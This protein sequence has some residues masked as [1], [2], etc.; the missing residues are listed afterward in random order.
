MSDPISYSPIGHTSLWENLDALERHYHAYLI[1]H[2]ARYLGLGAVVSEEWA[3]KAPLAELSLED[4]PR[5]ERIF[6]ERI[7]RLDSV[8]LI[9]WYERWYIRKEPQ[10][11]V[12]AVVRNPREVEYGGS[13]SS[14]LTKQFSLRHSGGK[15]YTMPDNNL[16]RRPL[17]VGNLKADRL[18]IDARLVYTV[19]K[20]LFGKLRRAGKKV[21]AA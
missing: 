11:T 2:G 13:S 4:A 5:I 19:P 8:A 18:G 10:P 7:T 3:R 14:V 15:L 12:I 6:S 1:G 17:E 16:T 9:L 21:R 20:R